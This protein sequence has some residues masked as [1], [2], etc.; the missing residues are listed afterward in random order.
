MS[1]ASDSEPEIEPLSPE[2]PKRDKNVDDL[3]KEL[4]S[5]TLY[6]E[7]DVERPK[8]HDA[9]MAKLHALLTSMIT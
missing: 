4:Q 7:E 1:S 5:I 9:G 8:Y 3:L 6:D 2:E